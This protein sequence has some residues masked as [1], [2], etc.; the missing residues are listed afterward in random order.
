MRINKSALFA[1]APLCM[2]PCAVARCDKSGSRR[3]C[4]STTNAANNV[5][6][7]VDVGRYSARLEGDVSTVLIADNFTDAA[8]DIYVARH[9]G[10]R[11]EQKLPIGSYPKRQESLVQVS[12]PPGFAVLAIDL[13]GLAV[14]VL[15]L[16]RRAER[17]T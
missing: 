15:L 6:D 1:L 3:A 8:R 7:F 16:R 14:L 11:S 10:E 4:I 12:E 2:A 13:S 17:E 5:A 9:Y